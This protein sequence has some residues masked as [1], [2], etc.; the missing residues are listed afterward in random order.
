MYVVAIGAITNVASAILMAPEIIEKIV[1]VWLGGNALYWPN[2][3][4]FNL[5]QDVPAAKVLFDCGVPLVQVPCMNVSSHLM[6]SLPEL[7]RH[8]EGKSPIGGYLTQIFRECTDNHYGYSR[9]IW[10]IS[11]IAYLVN[12]EWVPANVI[13]SPILTDQATWSMD[14]SR[15]FIKTA[16]HVERDRIF[17]DL[18]DKV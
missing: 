12:P 9:T 3:G 15:H 17:K 6:T 11:A 13:H 1:V 7:E 16:Y 10:D 8:I 14:N 5:I 18:F 4:E 2:N